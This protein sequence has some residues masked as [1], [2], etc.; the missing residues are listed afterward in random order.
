MASV[1]FDAEGWEYLTPR[2]RAILAR[3]ESEFSHSDP[4]LV[5]ALRGGVLPV[6]GWLVGIAR[7]ALLLSALVLLLPFAVWSSIVVLVALI[8]V[9]RLRRHALRG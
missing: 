9:V 5:D 7:A 3:I 1:P 4:R 6:P 8:L 2:E